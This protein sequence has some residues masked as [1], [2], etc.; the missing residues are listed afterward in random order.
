MKSLARVSLAALMPLFL[1]MISGMAFAQDLPPGPKTIYRSS[2]PGQTIQGEFELINLILDFDPGAATPPHIHGGPGIA[3]VLSEEIEFA[4]E[5]QAAFTAKPGEF[6]LDLPGMV[7]TAA[8]N[9][10]NTARASFVVALPKGAA[11]TTVV[12]GPPSDQLPPGPKAVYRTGLPN[13]TVQG[14]F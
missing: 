13:V 4:M 12:G 10:A 11:L 3:T 8:N 5:G 14:E 7:H 6:Y 9:T 2:L 1:L